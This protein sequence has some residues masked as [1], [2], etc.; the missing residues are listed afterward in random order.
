MHCRIQEL[1]IKTNINAEQQKLIHELIL[2]ILGDVTYEVARIW[3]S[4]HEMKN[5]CLDDEEY[6]KAEIYKNGISIT[7][8]I[9]EFLLKLSNE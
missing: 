5:K 8:E 3:A 1:A 7:D 6:D 9:A 4:Q 2:Q